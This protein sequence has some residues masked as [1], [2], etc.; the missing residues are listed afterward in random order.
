VVSLRTID[1]STKAHTD[2]I[3]TVHDMR[4]VIFDNSRVILASTFDADWAAYIEQAL[5]ALVDQA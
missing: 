1:R 2:Q 5:E 3:D 4:F